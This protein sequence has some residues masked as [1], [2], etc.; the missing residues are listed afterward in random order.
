VLGLIANAFV[1]PLADRWFM[2]DEEVA[3]TSNIAAT[4]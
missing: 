1:R 4:P 3:G 2:T